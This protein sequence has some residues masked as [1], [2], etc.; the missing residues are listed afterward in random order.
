MS[1]GQSYYVK[2]NAYQVG[3]RD[4]DWSTSNTVTVIGNVPDVEGLVWNGF[5]LKWDAVNGAQSYNVILKK[6][7]DNASS[8]TYG[9][10]VQ[11]DVSQNVWDTS[12]D[13]SSFITYYGFGTYLAKV[14][15]IDNRGIAVSNS[16]DSPTVSYGYTQISSVAVT[17]VAAPVAGATATYTASVP[18]GKG[19]EINSDI[20]SGYFYNGIAWYNEDD[21]KSVAATDTF[22]A[23]KKY[24]AM[25]ILKSASDSYIFSSSLSAT[26][27]GSAAEVT[28][29]GIVA[30]VQYTFTCPST[31][32]G[33]TV[34]G[35]VTSFLDN[36]G[37]VKVT[38][39]NRS[40][41]M[42]GF[43]KTVYGNSAS[44]SFTN[45]PAGLY[46]LT[47]SKKNH[48]T[49]TVT[50]G[51][52]GN[53]SDAEFKIHPLGDI[54]GDGLV[55]NGDY[56]RILAHLKGTKALEGYEIACADISGDGSVKNGD[57]SRVLAYLKGTKPLWE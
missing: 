1:V 35:T 15:A 9:M 24:T 50:I 49:K 12:F 39:V 7:D 25:I 56:S 17:G 51:I 18:T 41:N 32:T 20:T 19:Y 26:V 8:S 42:I 14:Q 37:A 10:Y 23:G 47:F 3:Y 22:V 44:F 57:L 6:Y 13:F 53:A 40:N 38:M 2:A 52:S 11:K 16:T 45:V 34:S 5:Q 28:G 30:V 4:S 54:N 21:K 48:A 55:K 43:T 33:Y 27:N 36:S 31:S 46:L 29:A